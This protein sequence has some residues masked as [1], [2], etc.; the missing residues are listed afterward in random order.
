VVPEETTP[1]PESREALE[2]ARRIL[3]QL[4]DKE[5]SIEQ[6]RDLVPYALDRL[7][8]VWR[9]I[10]DES[11]GRRTH[12]FG[13]WWAEEHTRTRDAVKALRNAELK[14][15]MKSTRKRSRFAIP[16]FVQVH[17]DGTI[18]V[19]REDGSEIESGPEGVRVTATEIESRWDFNVPGLEDRPVQ[20][21]LETVY[22]VLAERVLPTAERLLRET[23]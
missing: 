10:K 16:G 5:G 2:Q 23:E 18:T 7:D 4:P 13:T 1:L 6:Y 3:D 19:H 11:K 14:R 9:T 22:T 15:G 17:E 20:E 12:C 8:N 21:V